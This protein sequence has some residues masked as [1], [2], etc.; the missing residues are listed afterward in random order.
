VKLGNGSPDSRMVAKSFRVK[1]GRQ[2]HQRQTK[3]APLILVDFLRSVTGR[4]VILDQ[5]FDNPDLLLMSALD[6]REAYSK[7]AR[8]PFSPKNLSL[9]QFSRTLGDPKSTLIVSFENF[10]HPWWTDFARLLMTS[11]L[12]R[13]SF[14]PF[15]LDPGG[16][17]F[18]YWWNYLDWA[19]FPR[20]GAVYKRY[21]RLYSLDRL[22]SPVP[23]ATNRLD[24]A[25]W[26][27]SGLPAEPRKSFLNFTESQ[28][29]LDCFGQAG[30]PFE[31]AKSA[32]ME[33]YKY[34]VGAENSFGIGYDSEKVPEIW[35]S[36]CVPVGTFAQPMSDFNPLAINL[37]DPIASQRFP[38]LLAPPDPDPLLQ[39]L[40]SLVR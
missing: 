31:G 37:H 35:E 32:I 21:G 22:M 1:I 20:P 34:S 7:E 17:R 15:E 3:Q 38:L 8:K 27:G 16:A 30:T 9:S 33:R 19:D 28:V 18:P 6:L 25:C 4:E 14:F 13:T 39:Y 10:Q 24:K 2:F 26:I 23:K 12:P 11:D 36:G 29:G 5:A 40:D